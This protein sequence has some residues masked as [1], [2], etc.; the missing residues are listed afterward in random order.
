MYLLWYDD[1]KKPVAAKIRAALD[2]YHD[3]FH[4]AATVVLTNAAEQTPVA[5]V[6]VRSE[7]YIRPN[8]FWIGREEP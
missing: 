7:G 6:A 5:G 3:R 4:V 1:S 2:A 8:N